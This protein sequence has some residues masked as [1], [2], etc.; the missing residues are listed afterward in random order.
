[1]NYDC[2]IPQNRKPQQMPGRA[3]YWNIV[4]PYPIIPPLDL[5]S[6]LLRVV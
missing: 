2:I 6:M 1:M 5:L 4:I 3:L